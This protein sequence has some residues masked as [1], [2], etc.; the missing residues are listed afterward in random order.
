MFP[1]LLASLRSRP[2]VEPER[3]S[4]RI[5]GGRK[6][7][8]PATEPMSYRASGLRRFRKDLLN[9]DFEQCLR[10]FGGTRARQERPKR[11]RARQ[12]QWFEGSR[13]V[14]PRIL[15]GF[16]GSQAPKPRILRGF[17]APT[18]YK[19]VFYVVFE[20]PAGENLIFYVVFETATG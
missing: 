3:L 1:D 15:R 16:N 10:E 18:G 14:K 7:P 4:G 12:N 20:A 13:A 2:L 8:K 5:S 9:S 17:E 6:R 19:L 11:P